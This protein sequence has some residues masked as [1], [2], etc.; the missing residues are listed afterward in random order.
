MYLSSCFLMLTLRMQVIFL[1]FHKRIKNFTGSFIERE[2]QRKHFLTK[3]F[4][5]KKI[6]LY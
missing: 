3:T 5:S 1:K 2:L 6:F 4:I